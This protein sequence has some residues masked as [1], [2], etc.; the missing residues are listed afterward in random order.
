MRAYSIFSLPKP[1]TDEQRSHRRHTLARLGLSW[2]AAMQVMMFAFPGYMRSFST[3]AEDIESLSQVIVLMNWAGLCLTMPVVLY[4]S[5][6]IL[7]GAFKSLSEGRVG[8][9][10]P[11]A[12]GIVGAFLPSVYN[13]WMQQGEV[14]YD[15]V[16]M[17]VAFLLTARYLELCARQ[18]V[19]QSASHDLIER[20]RQT[21]TGHANTLAFW[22]VSIQLVLAAAF[23]LVW[24]WIDPSHVVPVVVAMLVMSCPCAMSMS[25]PSAVASA[26]ASL[27]ARPAQNEFEVVQLTQQT[28][29]IARQNLYGSIAWHLLMTPLAAMGIVAPWLAAV[30]MLV[31]SLAVAANSWRIYRSRTRMVPAQWTGPAA[32]QG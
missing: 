18:S 32:R 23:G 20:F 5:W 30:S 2:L 31:S 8:M 21:V 22:F 11:V 7:K 17:F 28:G 19:T 24:Y 10:V 15:S 13:T 6:P 9:D 29:R 16:T 1:L 4:C 25:V 27:L 26:H 12:L 3:R 14:Y